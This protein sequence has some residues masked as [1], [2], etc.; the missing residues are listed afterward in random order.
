M[1]FAR[2]LRTAITAFTCLTLTAPA[3]A[4]SRACWDPQTISAARVSE[5]E[6][7]LMVASLRCKSIGIDMSQ[8]FDQFLKEHKRTLEPAHERL[9]ARY[10]SKIG[11]AI[12]T[13]DYDRFVTGV[14][15]TYG[16]GRTELGIC[17]QFQVLLTELGKAGATAEFLIGVAMEMVREPRLD[18]DRCPLPPGK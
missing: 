6:T 18:G 17:N 3:M 13:S 12:K 15:N 7:L 16:M 2:S 10:N 4:Q 11:K 14:A 8:H 1:T 9:R 5:F